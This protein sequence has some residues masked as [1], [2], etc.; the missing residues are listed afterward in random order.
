MIDVL[1]DREFSTTGQLHSS[2]CSASACSR[3]TDFSQRRFPPALTT[4]Y[5]QMT[6]LT[7]I[8]CRGKVDTGRRWRFSISDY[9]KSEH[10]SDYSCYLPCSCC[11][12]FAREFPRAPD[13]LFL[14]CLS[15]HRGYSLIQHKQV[16]LFI[17][18]WTREE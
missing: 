12:C 3:W 1:N 13:L 18:L 10:I 16:F 9:R 15:D 2:R 5:R 14:Q 17:L 7:G 11:S 6:I 8:S 4:G